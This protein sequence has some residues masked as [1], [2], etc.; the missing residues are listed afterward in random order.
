[1]V[2][3]D[4]K[5]LAAERRVYPFVLLIGLILL[6]AGII[7]ISNVSAF[8]AAVLAFGIGTAFF[9]AGFFWW[10]DRMFHLED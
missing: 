6:F 9:S 7:M 8:G 2:K 5:T 3:F 4:E 1:V 10:I